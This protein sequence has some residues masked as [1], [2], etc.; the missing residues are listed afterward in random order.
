MPRKEG[1]LLASRALSIIFGVFALEEVTY[2]PERLFAFLHYTKDSKLLEAASR[3]M[4]LPTLYRVEVGSLFV[5]IAIYLLLAVAFWNCRPWIE[6]I[7]LP[8]R[9]P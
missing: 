5:R 9:E 2:L 1:V 3:S 6:R 8:E 4:Y 7:L